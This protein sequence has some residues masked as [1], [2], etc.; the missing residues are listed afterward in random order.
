MADRTPPLCTL[1][2][3]CR[4]AK[5][6]GWTRA[7]VREVLDAHHARWKDGE[8]TEVPAK[9]RQ[10]LLTALTHHPSWWRQSAA[11]CAQLPAMDT[12]YAEL[13]E[14]CGRLQWRRP[15]MMDERDRRVLVLLLRDR[16]SEL[17]AAIRT[18]RAGKERAA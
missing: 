6:I 9:Q 7:Q 11:F 17:W 1:N 5:N 16:E 13:A 12:D 8:L 4:N 15:S 18:L 14:A 2:E 3:A 10:R